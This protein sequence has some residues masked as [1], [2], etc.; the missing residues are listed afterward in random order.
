MGCHS[1][2]QEIFLTQE[3]NPRLLHLLHW[4]AYSL[5]LSHVGSAP[6]G[7]V[8]TNAGIHQASKHMPSFF[9]IPFHLG[10]SSSSQQGI[11]HIKLW[12]LNLWYLFHTIEQWIRIS[13]AGPQ[14]QVE[15]CR[16]QSSRNQAPHPESWR[17]QV[18]YTSGSRGVN[19]PSS[20][21]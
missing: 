16:N 14:E 9:T 8:M 12:T 18:Y 1:L 4:Q 21:P 3:S 6:R 15:Y 5:P 10:P 20:E 19:S 7:H 17:T 11:F 13:T 2:I